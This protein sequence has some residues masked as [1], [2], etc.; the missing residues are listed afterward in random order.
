[1]RMT[2][3]ML[4]SALGIFLVA[5][6]LWQGW[7]WWQK[8]QEVS[9]INIT[10]AYDV[11][12]LAQPVF[13][14]FIY[15]E[16]IVVPEKTKVAA[17]RV[18]LFVPEESEWLQIDIRQ[19][20]QLLSRWRYQPDDL[21]QNSVAVA[22]LPLNPPRI[23]AGEVE[24][25]F[26]GSHIAYEDRPRAP[27]VFIDTS[28]MTYPAGSYR[29]AQNEKRGN[30]SLQLQATQK[31]SE[32]WRAEFTKAPL[33]KLIRTSRWLLIL[34]VIFASPRVLLPLLSGGVASLPQKLRGR[35][36]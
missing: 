22:S 12:E 8:E 13:A 10:G 20:G 36:K 28:D 21:A 33:Q 26:N 25:V 34:I 5:G 3:N 23:M 31:N 4:A 35:S 32:H 11:P 17:L 9:V 6:C 29:I 15:T 7:R 2:R 30:I 18:P 14:Q 16:K 27:R 19:N 24:V 1:M